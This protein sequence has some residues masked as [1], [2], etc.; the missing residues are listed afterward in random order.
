MKDTPPKRPGRKPEDDFSEAER[1]LKNAYEVFRELAFFF[2]QVFI[3]IL[4]AIGLGISFIIWSQSIGGSHTPSGD[5]DIFSL[6]LREIGFGLIVAAISV[7]GYESLHK[8]RGDHER[9]KK[10]D[11][12]VRSLEEALDTVN[13]VGDVKPFIQEMIDDLKATRLEKI[14][15]AG[16]SP[17]VKEE[18]EFKNKAE[19]LIRRVWELKETKTIYSKAY[20]RYIT[21][22]CDNL[23]EKNITPI[24]KVEESSESPEIFRLPSNK[25]VAS[26]LLGSQLS[27]LDEGDLYETM[28]NFSFWDDDFRFFWEQNKKA[29]ERGV[30]IH[31]LFYLRTIV[32]ASESGTLSDGAFARVKAIAD[33]HIELA[34]KTGNMYQIR[35]L[36]EAQS[37]RALENDPEEQINVGLDS[38]GVFSHKIAPETYDRLSFKVLTAQLTGINISRVAADIDSYLKTFTMMWEIAGKANPFARDKDYF[39]KVVREMDSNL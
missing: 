21:W 39:N 18:L 36:T 16:F 20:L 8:V 2:L 7:F 4:L 15:Q 32:H 23:L 14:E 9:Q 33:R 22:L 25:S 28:S 13:A 34:G 1:K 12:T 26:Q 37:D 3:L 24:T 17:D 6:S 35:F 10:M 11:G 38:F 5:N 30:E 31:R 27:C 29:C 19:K